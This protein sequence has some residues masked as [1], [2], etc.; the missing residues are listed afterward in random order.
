MMDKEDVEFARL[1]KQQ[2]FLEKNKELIHRFI[3]KT[4]EKVF[5]NSLFKNGEEQND[6]IWFLLTSYMGSIF[7]ILQIYCEKSA[8]GYLKDLISKT[9]KRLK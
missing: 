2:K 4:E 3:S 8:K 6:A 5:K 9:F 1:W 7:Q